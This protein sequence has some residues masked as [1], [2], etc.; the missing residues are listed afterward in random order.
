MQEMLEAEMTDALGAAK[1]ERS[2]GRLGYRL[3]YYGGRWSLAWVS[4]SCAFRN[5]GT[6]GVRPSCLSVINDPSAR[7]WWPWPRCCPRRFNAQSQND[8]GRTLRP[9][10]LGLLDRAINKR[11]D[12][13][14]AAFAKRPLA[15]PFPYLIL[16]ARYERVRDAGIVASQAVLIAIGID[17]S[18]RRQ[19]LAVEV[20]PIGRASSLG[21][22]SWS[23]WR[24]AVFTASILLS[25]MIMPVCGPPFARSFRRRLTSAVMFTFLRNALDHLPRKHSDHC[26]QKLRSLSWAQQPSNVEPARW[27][28]RLIH[29][30]G[31][32]RYRSATGPRTQIPPQGLLSF[33]PKRA[34]P[35]LYSDAKIKGILRATLKMPCRYERGALTAMG[36]LLSIRTAQR[37]ASAPRQARDVG[38]RDMDLKASALTIRGAKFGKTRLVPLHASTCK[39]LGDYIA[40]RQSHW[41]GRVVSSYVSLQF[42]RSLGWRRYSFERSMLYPD[43]SASGEDRTVMVRV[44]D[45]RHNSDCRIIPTV[46]PENPIFRGVPGNPCRNNR[47][48]KGSSGKPTPDRPGDTAVHL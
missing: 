44:H 1:D 41:T 47:I 19:I 16:G 39:V 13:G 37:F 21:R 9:F 43:R 17:W 35:Y 14:L 38:L 30:R 34:R 28:Q 36:L 42:G 4:L 26:P 27:A 45:M 8:N 20:V 46:A 32:A 29:V 6:D 12:E 22:T 24:H 7:W 11:L 2:E 31:F 15:E 3:G 10:V 33:K 40:R 18:G 25:P 5:V 48:I 23:K